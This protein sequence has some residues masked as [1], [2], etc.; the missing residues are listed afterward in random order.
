M[1]GTTRKGRK[2]RL[3][4]RRRRSGTLAG[5]VLSEEK[6][7]EWE[8]VCWGTHKGEHRGSAT[9]D[10]IYDGIKILSSHSADAHT[11]RHLRD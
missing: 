10:E 8:E 2:G 3:V 9:V 5:E 6:V 7:V 1:I 4:G 11:T